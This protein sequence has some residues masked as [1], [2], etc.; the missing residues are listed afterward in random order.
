[1]ANFKALIIEDVEANRLVKLSYNE[2]GDA[3]I[4]LAKTGDSPD[5]YSTS[6]LVEG[7]MA[8]VSVKGIPVWRVEAGGDIKAGGTVKIGGTTGKIMPS[9]TDIVGYVANEV[10]TGEIAQLIHSATG[11]GGEKGPTGDKGPDGSPG[12]AGA[13]GNKG[14]EGEKGPDGDK[15]PVG[16]KGPTGDKGP[17]GEPAP[18]E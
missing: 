5:F 9:E 10:K 18:V 8:N 11:G 15:G 1:M 13:D 6:N 17:D 16:N 7:E 4:S 12:T 14:P 2:E 3:T